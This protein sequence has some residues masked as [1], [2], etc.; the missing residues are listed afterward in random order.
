MAI[1]STVFKVQLSIADLTRHYYQDHALTVAR[2]PSETDVRM[3][4]RLVVFALNAHEHLQFTKGLGSVEEPDLW[5]IDLT[6]EIQHWI[7][8]GQPVEKRIRQSCS[9][10]NRVSIYTYQRGAANAW[11]ESIKDQILRFKHLSITHLAVLD[12]AVVGEM[13]DRTMK[14]H[15]LIDEDRVLLTDDAHS[16]TV[17][18]KSLKAVS[19]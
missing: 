8:L 3:L 4:M 19:T 7:E 12:E 13:V 2:H 14:L 11:L 18:L 6:G 10:A 15:C 5:Q 1:K 9:K 17:E 16:L